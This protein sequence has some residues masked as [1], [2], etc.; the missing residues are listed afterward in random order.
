MNSE[1]SFTNTNSGPYRSRLT[2]RFLTHAKDV[3]QRERA[4][5][6]KMQAM[7][8][9][10]IDDL[11]AQRL[12]LEQQQRATEVTNFGGLQDDRS[13][14]EQFAIIAEERCAIADEIE[15][16]RTIMEALHEVER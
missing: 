15:E 16:L 9:V 12:D 4:F 13:T 6:E 5:D 2:S 10:A 1:N 11:R 8:D 7:H 14:D 3:F